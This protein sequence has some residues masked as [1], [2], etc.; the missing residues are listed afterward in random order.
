ME[1]FGPE[2]G[3]DADP[4]AP[5]EV[6]GREEDMGGFDP[7]LFRIAVPSLEGPAL[8]ASEAEGVDMKVGF[9]TVLV[10]ATGMG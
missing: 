9:F 7:V 8:C 10:G 6:E 4:K 1:P 3:D 5:P 2:T